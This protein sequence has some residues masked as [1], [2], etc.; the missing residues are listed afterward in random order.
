MDTEALLGLRPRADFARN[1]AS[2]SE[3]HRQCTCST[4]EVHAGVR[5]G[6]GNAD[7]SRAAASRTAP[8]SATEAGALPAVRGIRRASPAA[9]AEPTASTRNPSR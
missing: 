2:A 8:V 5:T 4:S 1:W 9:A 6:Q 7:Y 3:H